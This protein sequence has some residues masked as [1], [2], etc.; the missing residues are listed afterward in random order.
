M[1][2]AG[3][4]HQGLVTTGIFIVL[5][6]MSWKPPIWSWISLASGRGS[7]ICWVV[8]RVGPGRAAAGR[9]DN[10]QVGRTAG[11]RSTATERLV[12]SKA[13][14]TPTPSSYELP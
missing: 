4:T 8:A 12:Y 11:W 9:M 5:A 2:S 13:T 6:E 3:P 14:V 7:S 10:S 1:S